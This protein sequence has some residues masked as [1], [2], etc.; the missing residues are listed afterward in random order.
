MPDRLSEAGRRV[1]LAVARAC[2]P[3]GARLDGAGQA[4]VD[5]LEQAL[6][7]IDPRA[8]AGY[9]AVLQTLEQEA[10]LAHGGRAFS[11]LSPEEA[12]R[13]L[14]RLADGGVAS[15]ALALAVTMPLKI[16]YFDD[17]D[18]YREL[19]SPWGFTATDEPARWRDQMTNL[20]ACDLDVR[21]HHR[22]HPS[23]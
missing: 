23:D 2:M 12:E 10:R 6:D 13:H 9:G 17:A 16:A 15:R 1:A 4:T 19:R 11:A 7:E 21:R 5:K 3:S 22:A 8:I 14:V 20:D 18:V